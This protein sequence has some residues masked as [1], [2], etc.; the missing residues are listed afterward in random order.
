MIGII[1]GFLLK[2]IQSESNESSKRFLAIY[3]TLFLMTYVVLAFTNDKNAE[4]ILA[5]LIG[6]V[7]VLC[8]VAAWE[9][10][11]RTK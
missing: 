8:G 1:W 2:L 11:K 7:L 4:F 3:G 6:F 10:V 9:R 5:E